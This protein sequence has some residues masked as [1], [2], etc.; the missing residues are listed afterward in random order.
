MLQFRDSGYFK[1]TDTIIVSKVLFPNEED[2]TYKEAFKKAFPNKNVIMEADIGHIKPVM[3]IINGSYV[4]I[5][6]KD[7]LMEMETDLLI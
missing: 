7:H 1:Y 5:S 6:F 4:N 2:M 3:T